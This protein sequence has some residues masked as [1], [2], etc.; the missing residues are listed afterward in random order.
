MRFQDTTALVTGG[1]SGIGRAIALALAGEGA[2]VAVNDLREEAAQAVVGEIEAAGG[3]ALAAPADV[4]DG[5][6]VLKMF[7][8]FLT[9]WDGLDVLVNNA[10]AIFVAP[11]VLANVQT[12]AAEVASGQPR[13]T[14]I[15]ATATLEDGVW[16][17]TL[18]IHLDGTFHCTREALKVMQVRR[19]GA[20]VNMASVAGTGGIAGAPDYSAAKAGIIGFTKSV[21]KEVAHLGIRVNAVA[22]GFIDTPLLEALGD[23][24]RALY[25]AQTPMGRLGTVAEVAA[26]ALYLAAPEAGFVTGQVLSPNGGLEI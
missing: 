7:T 8:R 24:L 6:A 19:R 13:A 23:D 3:R 22:P 12:L 20:I 9:V 18:A 5:R 1:G 10:G 21:A 25:R 4:A 14:A 15:D 2:R 17:R 26:A 11:H 16:R